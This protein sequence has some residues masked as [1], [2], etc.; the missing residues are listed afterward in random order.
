MR[1]NQNDPR[2]YTQI[3]GPPLPFPLSQGERFVSSN[4]KRASD[5]Y[6]RIVTSVKEGKD[7]KEVSKW[8]PLL[9]LRDMEDGEKYVG[10]IALLNIGEKWVIGGM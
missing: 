4:Q 1:Y 6:D 8:F 3:Q 7:W 2:I 5:E 10:E 9:I